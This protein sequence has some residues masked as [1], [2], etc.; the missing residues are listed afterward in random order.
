M[1]FLSAIGALFRSTHR[2]Q[3]NRQ[4]HHM[5]HRIVVLGAGGTFVAHRILAVAT[6]MQART[7]GLDGL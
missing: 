7:E 2:K 6:Q 4:E 3:A 1:Q 5:K